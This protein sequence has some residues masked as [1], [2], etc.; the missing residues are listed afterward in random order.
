MLKITD[1]D[2]YLPLIYATEGINV[3]SSGATQPM[4]IRGICSKSHE[5]NEYV[6]KYRS[7]PRMSIEAQCRELIAAFI[8]CELGLYVAQPVIINI[9]EDFIETLRGREGFAYANGSIGLNFGSKYIAGGLT[10][11]IKGQELSNRQYNEAQ[12]VFALD[13]FITNPDRNENKQNM[14]TDGENILIFDHELAFGFVFDI[15]KNPTPWLITEADEYWIKLHYFYPIIKGNEHN[16][17]EFVKS[18]EQLND[19]FWEKV[20]QLIP[21]EWKCDQ[22]NIIKN[23]ITNLVTNRSIFINELTRILS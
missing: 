5:V 17:D 15:I 7:S 8:A 9:T 4:L 12:K 22:V 16:L 3:L 18:F 23:N 6:V 21:D 14:L 20:W 1:P 13:V 19:N 2:Y 11:F 10:P